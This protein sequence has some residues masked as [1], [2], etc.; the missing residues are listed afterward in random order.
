MNS[1]PGT[2][3]PTD[4]RRTITS[5]HVR[6]YES[7]RSAH[8]ERAHELSPATIVYRERRYDFDCRLVEGLDLVRTS[9]LGAAF[10]LAR[11]RPAIVEINEPLMTSSLPATALALVGLRAGSLFCRRK[12]S[13]VTYAIENDNPFG[14]A[15][16]PRLRGRIRCRLEQRLAMFVWSHVDRVAFGTDGARHVYESA[17]GQSH[18]ATSTVLALPA[19][20]VD[21]DDI[22]DPARVLFVGA[23]VE[24]KG[25]RLLLDAWPSVLADRPDA[26]LTIVGKGALEHE[27]RSRIALDATI[28]LVVDPPRDQ[29]R[30][31]YAQA[32][33]ATLPSQPSPRWREQVGLPIVEAL[34]AGCRIVTTDQTGL[35]DWLH[36]HGH[37]VI[38]A[39][40]PAD[41]LAVA[42]VAALESELSRGEVRASLPIRDGRLAA[43]DWLISG[44]PS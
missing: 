37:E 39:A 4:A 27:I 35:A 29:I 32:A 33:V 31:R 16:P 10:L 17:L 24:R 15:R 18:G 14:R 9:R 38:E 6:L 42:L 41:R 25:V 3:D 36:R 5:G 40:A 22:Y 20:V 28:E 8:L 2:A 12:P 13:V 11:T 44:L 26:R 34:S 23:L 43:D 21:A 30:R 19:P 1:P 7:V